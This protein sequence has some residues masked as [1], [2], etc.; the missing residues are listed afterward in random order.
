MS[1]TTSSAVRAAGG[2]VLRRALPPVLLGVVGL[3]AWQALVV[4]ADVPPFLLPSPTAIVEQLVEVGPLVLEASLATG[5]N[6]L[7]GTLLGA[8]VAVLAALLAARSRPV[9]A[10][11]S[12]TAAA[13]AVLP[14][15]ALA[16]VLNTMFGTTTTTPRRLVVAAVV[17][18]PVFVTTLRGLRQ[19]LPVHRELLRSYAATPAQLARTVTIPG[20]LPYLFTGL[21]IASST[22]VIAAV[23]AEYFGGLQDGLGSRITSAAANSAYPRAWAFVV[24]AILLGLAVYLLTLAAERLV[25]R[26]QGL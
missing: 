19:V 3:A 25:A 24:G 11:L 17:F 9:D 4:A 7:V 1:T 10:V 18:A 5:A 8:V 6:V 15:V 22:G 12:P 16:P 23:V 13:I 14:I 21:R 20:A 2:D 26:R